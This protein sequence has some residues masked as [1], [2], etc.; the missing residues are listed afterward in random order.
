MADFSSPQLTTL[1]RLTLDAVDRQRIMLDVA[2]R[3]AEIPDELRAEVQATRE[4]IRAEQRAASAYLGELELTA[5]ELGA[6]SPATIRDEIKVLRE[7]ADRCD[8]A[9]AQLIA[10]SIGCEQLRAE[11]SDLYQVAWRLLQAPITGD[12][13]DGAIEYWQRRNELTTLVAAI[14]RSQQLAREEAQLATN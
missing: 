9:E 13:Q 3:K 7:R 2:N 6:E 10:H 4:A 8:Q 14:G 1:L 12:H 5:E 11:F